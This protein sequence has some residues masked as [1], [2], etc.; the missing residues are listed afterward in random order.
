MLRRGVVEVV[1][2]DGEGER[3]AHA[4]KV[5]HSLPFL[6]DRGSSDVL[7]LWMFFFFFFFIFFFYFFYR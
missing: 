4:H 2:W 7:V 1:R 6:V 5:W 3:L